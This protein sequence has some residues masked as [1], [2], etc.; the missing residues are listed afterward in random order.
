VFAHE[1]NVS[2]IAKTLP[3]LLVTSSNAIVIPF[4]LSVFFVTPVISGDMILA[5]T[6]SRKAEL[7]VG[8]SFYFLLT[9]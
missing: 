9:Y 4:T 7:N 2:L 3:Q 1:S 8:V 6:N 5:N